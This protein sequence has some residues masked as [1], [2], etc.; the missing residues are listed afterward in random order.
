VSDEVS[1]ATSL[2]EQCEGILQNFDQTREKARPEN[3]IRT[4]DAWMLGDKVPTLRKNTKASSTPTV[5]ARVALQCSSVST[6][7]DG[8][9]PFGLAVTES[10]I[11]S[12][13]SATGAGMGD[14]STSDPLL[15]PIPLEG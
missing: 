9:S 11:S 14:P 6:I 8:T 2:S 13:S 10:I 12:S 15:L 1:R 5:I 7:V 3:R 4:L